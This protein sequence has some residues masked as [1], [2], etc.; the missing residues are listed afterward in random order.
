MHFS[1]SGLNEPGGLYRLDKF[2]GTEVMT[3]GVLI[4]SVVLMAWIRYVK[5]TLVKF[6]AGFISQSS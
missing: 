3:H 2:G 6:T 5:C 4:K 1:L